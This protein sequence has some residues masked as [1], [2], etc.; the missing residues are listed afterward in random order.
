MVAP[1]LKALP[2]QA[3]SYARA[4]PP[5][6]RSSSGR[7]DGMPHVHPRHRGPVSSEPYL[8]RLSGMMVI[9]GDVAING[10]ASGRSWSRRADPPWTNQWTTDV[11]SKVVPSGCPPRVESTPPPDAG[12]LERLVR[13]TRVD[14]PLRHPDDLRRRAIGTAPSACGTPVAAYPSFA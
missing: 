9:S 4:V 1:Y 3:L 7:P 6:A 2:D 13:R 5:S 8:R 11:E 10:R 14:T 12:S